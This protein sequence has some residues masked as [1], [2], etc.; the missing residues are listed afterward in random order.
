[1]EKLLKSAAALLLAAS[2][3]LNASAAEELKSAGTL[4][5]RSSKDAKDTAFG[6]CVYNAKDIELAGKAG[7]S[8]VRRDISWTTVERQKGVYDFKGHDKFMQEL[9]DWNM[10]GLFILG[11]ASK[12]YGGL[13]FVDSQEGLDAWAAAV[14]KIVERYKDSAIGW[15]VWNEANIPIFFDRP[16]EDYMKVLKAASKAIR[17]ADPNAVI[18]MTGTSETDLPFIKKCLEAGAADYVDVIAYHPYRPLPELAESNQDGDRTYADTMAKLKSLVASYGGGRLRIWNTEHGIQSALPTTGVSYAMGTSELM[19]AKY[20]LRRLA[21]ESSM[22][23]ERSV[24]FYARQTHLDG[25][26]TEYNTK[27]L[28]NEDRSPKH[29]YFAVQNMLSIFDKSV[30]PSPLPFEFGP[31]KREEAKAASSAI[32]IEAESGAI[33]R[34]GGALDIKRDATASGGACLATPDSSIAYEARKKAGGYRPNEPAGTY[35]NK[36][37]AEFKFEIKGKG[38]YYI[39]GRA[40]SPFMLGTSNS[41]FVK[42]DDEQEFI[43]DTPESGSEWRWS[44]I[45]QRNAKDS[46][47]FELEP[48]E[49]TLRFRVRE[50]GTEL[51]AIQIAE[52]LPASVF[53]DAPLMSASFQNADGSPLFAYWKATEIIEWQSV[54][55][56]K[57]SLFLKSSKIREPVLIDTLSKE[58]AVYKLD[59]FDLKDGGI[60]IRNVPV[61]DYPL[62]VADKSSVK[63]Q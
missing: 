25:S 37:A 38:R 2:P 61:R 35:D 8:F 53:D 46:G 6:V 21:L 30:K 24:V 18:T 31:L 54:P 41:F 19:Q 52:S 9:K 55:E 32:F 49:H 39:F 51:D 1:M 58:H 48:G 11:G 3:F 40:K 13:S 45:G 59:D 47:A 34:S 10:K 44:Y 43:W 15:E 42:L 63:L 23:L 62:I 57:A 7:F 33:K 27:A 28:C 4:C 20:L 22:G 5:V 14:G 12:L 17:A 60:L 50:D 56:A 16:Q 29:S 26:V 36:D